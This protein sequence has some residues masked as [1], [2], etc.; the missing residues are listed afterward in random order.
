LK[1]V[2]GRVSTETSA[3]LSFDTPALIEEGRLFISMYA[4]MGL[5]VSAS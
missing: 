5:T 1:I 2:P 4:K 3:K